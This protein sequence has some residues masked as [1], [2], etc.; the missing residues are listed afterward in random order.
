MKLLSKL[1]QCA[2]HR[3]TYATGP[4]TVSSGKLEKCSQLLLQDTTLDGRPAN[5]RKM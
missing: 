4:V 1:N 2:K 5:S 3:W